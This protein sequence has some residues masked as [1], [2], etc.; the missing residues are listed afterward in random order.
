MIRRPIEMSECAYAFNQTY[1]CSPHTDNV[2]LGLCYRAGPIESR[3]IL[4][5]AGNLTS[6]L[7]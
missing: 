1:L 4:A 2:Q 3:R 7:G 6:K 5:T